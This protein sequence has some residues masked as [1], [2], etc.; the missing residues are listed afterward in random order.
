M[1]VPINDTLKVLLEGIT[2]L[3]GLSVN[4]QLARLADLNYVIPPRTETDPVN[5]PLGATWTN[6][7]DGKIK[8][9]TAAGVREIATDPIA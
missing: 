7:T 2:G 1:V 3:T 8:Q 4:D 6:T 9:Q 5:P